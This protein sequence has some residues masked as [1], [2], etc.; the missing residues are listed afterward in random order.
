MVCDNNE[1]RYADSQIGYTLSNRH[2][3]LRIGLR[4]AADQKSRAHS[5]VNGVVSRPQVFHRAQLSDVSVR[6]IV[7]FLIVVG[8]GASGLP[9]ELEEAEFA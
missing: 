2:V 7:I 1:P 5:P 4:I 8:I 3:G 9:R 6:R